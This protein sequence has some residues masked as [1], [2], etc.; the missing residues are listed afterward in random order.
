MTSPKNHKKIW[1]YII[2]L[3]VSALALIYIIKTQDSEQIWNQ[4]KTTK[5]LFFIV[6]LLF[7]VLSQWVSSLRLGKLLH[8]IETPISK[9][10]NF[11]LYLE[12]MAY[13]LFLP[14]GIGGDA[15]KVFQIKKHFQTPSKMTVKAILYDRLSG[16][17]AIL[18]LLL[19]I[20]PYWNFDSGFKPPLWMCWVLIALGIIISFR[21][22]RWL[23]KEL[24]KVFFNTV[25]LSIAIQ[26]LQILSLFCLV[27]N[28]HPE[29]IGYSWASVFLI[30]SIATVIPVFLGGMGAREGVFVL[31]ASSIPASSEIA[32]TVALQF[33]LVV[34]VSSLPG[35]FLKWK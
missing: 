6:A 14:G 23:A 26:C 12:G 33:S 34:F 15:Y 5:P 20:Y 31:L 25:L 7:Y 17:L 19:L 4:L 8:Q 1:S 3:S 10:Q 32:F 27:M 9:R 16:L 13:N 29:F 22:S 28:W 21:F 24:H 11:I 18:I 2:K 30:S 35:L